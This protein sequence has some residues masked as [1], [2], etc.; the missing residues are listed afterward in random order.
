MARHS[1]GKNN[2]TLSGGAIAVLVALLLILALVLWLIFGRSDSAEQAKGG[3]CVSGD[4]ELP[5]AA[6]DQGVGQK[7]VDAYAESAPVVRDYCVKPKLVDN[8]SDAAVYVAPD[9]PLTHKTIEDAKRTAAVSD[10]ETVATQAVGVAGEKAIDAAEIDLGAVRFPAGEQPSASAVVAAKLAGE[11]KDR[12]VEALTQQRVESLADF[13]KTPD[14]FVATA[15]DATPEGLVFSPV[16]ASV[17]YAAIPLNASEGIDEN[18]SRAGQDFARAQSQDGADAQPTIDDA[19]WAAAFGSG[20]AANDPAAEESKAQ[21]APQKQQATAHAE[22]TLFLLDTS[23]AMA[24][25]LQPAKDAIGEAA[26]AV[27]AKKKMVG[28]WNYSSPLN[29]GV[30]RGYRVN[31]ALTPSAEEVD[32]AVHR[33]LT[34]GVPQ[35]REALTAAASASAGG[36]DPVRIVLVTTGTADAGED[37]DGAAFADSLQQYLDQGVEVAVVHVGDAT[38]DA[39]VERVAAT[40]AKASGPEQ[41]PEALATATGTK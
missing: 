12:A 2:Y 16:D 21:E 39:G 20:A 30:T 35:T 9:T 17:Q 29:E 6:S 28:L 38:P 22:H 31:V 7:V 23:D 34:G 41:L 14:T 11:N 32:V 33:F 15:E 37:V 10:P 24:P 5:V 4:L 1:N 25:F 19:V 13:E 8:V 26:G 40:H 18:Q 27:A 3:E 36:E